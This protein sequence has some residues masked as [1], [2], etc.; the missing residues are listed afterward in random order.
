MPCLSFAEEDTSKD[1]L[2]SGLWHLSAGNALY[3]MKAGYI[4][5]SG[6]VRLESKSTDD[7]LEFREGS[8]NRND[9]TGEMYGGVIFLSENDFRINGEKIQKGA[10]ESYSVENFSLTTCDNETPT[11]SITGA[12]ID[13]AVQGFGTLKNAAFRIKDFP[14]FYL[15]Y[16]IFPAKTKRQTGLLLPQFDHSNINGYG[17]EIP[18]FWAVSDHFDTTLYE[19]FLSSRGLLQGVEFRYVTG[20]ASHGE[21]LFDI[22]KD[23]IA[24]KD[25]TDLDQAEISPFERVNEIRYWLRGRLDQDISR[26]LTARLD[27]DVVS[28]QDYLR[29]FFGQFTGFEARPD[30]AADFGRPMEERYSSFRRSA[31]RISHDGENYSLQGSGYY[32]QRPENQGEDTTSQPLGGIF[33]SL[34]PEQFLKLPVFYSMNTDYNYIWR[35]TGIK[36]HS[37]SVMPKISYPQRLGERLKL[38]T[39]FGYTANL[40]YYDTA[41]ENND[42]V[43]KDAYQAR[44]ELSTILERIF[45]FGQENVT[46]LKHK[47]TPI[48]AYEY[49]MLPDEQDKSPWFNPI[50][51]AT[52]NNRISLSIENL[53]DK[54]SK[55][56]DGNVSYFKWAQFDITQSYNIEELQRDDIADADKKVWEPLLATLILNPFKSLYFKGNAAW[57]HYDDRLSASVLSANVSI[58][59]AGEANDSYAID[60][61]K[62]YDDNNSLNLRADVNLLS[63]VSAGGLLNRDLD[64]KY[65]IYSGVWLKYQ[66]QCWSIKLMMEK[67]DRDRNI[68]VKF[69]LAGF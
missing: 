39:S 6:N 16:M 3:D 10:N 52:K 18:F 47:V 42:S 36:G 63:G 62:D 67:E 15:P 59:R 8:F 51:A 69:G 2:L 4:K 55:D 34:L 60:Y 56:K 64:M 45:A 22:L 48:V 11:W 25:L 5:L 38:D 23:K 17:F 20:Y 65:N 37:L 7:V 32:Y 53:L 44:V 12:K 33:Y 54:S 21:F 58:P 66:A 29:E 26:D 24:E 35:D 41:Y 43:I 68:I 28:D 31:L 30:L 14:V 50:D 9:G 61:V 57:D 40:E 1:D 49:S 19:R 46:R 27:L 13:I